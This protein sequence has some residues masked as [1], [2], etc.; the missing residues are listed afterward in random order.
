MA[1]ANK[2]LTRSPAGCA[3]VSSVVRSCDD[4]RAA[5]LYVVVGH[6]AE[7]VKNTVSVAMLHK[8]LS[9]VYALRYRDGMSASLRAGISSLPSWI[10]GAFI[11]LGDMPLVEAEL[12][13]SMIGA[14]LPNSSKDIVVPRWQNRRGNP[15]LWSRRYFA[16]MCAL[17][18]DAGARGLL[19]HYAENVRTVDA[20]GPSVVL[21]I[22]T[23]DAAA[24]N[25][26]QGRGT[27]A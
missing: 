15:I 1:P 17:S 27:S 5:C 23:S 18:G 3:M 21:D 7:M 19:D 14:F 10:D 8:P 20:C 25:I 26:W 9:F 6:Q 2:L 13:D 4:S 11:C 16:K 12:M 22:D 24:M